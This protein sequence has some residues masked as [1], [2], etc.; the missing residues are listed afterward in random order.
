MYA[1][2]KFCCFGFSKVS[3]RTKRKN[4]FPV[5]RNTKFNKLLLFT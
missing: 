3:D 5:K 4:R 1:L 2:T